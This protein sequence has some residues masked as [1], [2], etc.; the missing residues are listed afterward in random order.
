MN[1]NLYDKY[2]TNLR[3]C[4]KLES[5]VLKATKNKNPS[6]LIYILDYINYRKVK[7]DE[8]YAWFKKS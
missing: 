2:K 8:N 3:Q 5:R 4:L 7:E 1:T 6:V